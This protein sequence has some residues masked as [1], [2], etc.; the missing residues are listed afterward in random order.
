MKHSTSSRKLWTLAGLLALGLAVLFL[1]LRRRGGQATSQASTGQDIIPFRYIR[2]DLSGLSEAEA[3][4]KMPAF[5]RAQR[6]QEEEK[7]F[8]RRAFRLN[9]LSTFNIDIFAIALVMLL[10]GSPI[11][12]LGSM[13]V[14]LLNVT[15]N[16]VQITMTKKRL[17][18]ILATLSPQ[19]TVLRDSKLRSIDPVQIVEGDLLVI[20]SG[21]HILVDGELLSQESLTVEAFKPDQTT[22]QRVIDRGGSMFKGEDCVAGHGLYRAI[23]PGFPHYRVSPGSQVQLLQGERTPLENMMETILRGLLALVVVFSIV[24]VTGYVFPETEL[25]TAVYREAFSIVFAIAPTSLFFVLIMQYAMGAMRMSDLGAL[26]YKSQSIEALSNVSVICLSESSLMSGFEAKVEPISPPPGYASLSENTIR[27]FIGDAF[28]SL[29]AFS[30]LDWRSLDLFPGKHRQ[31]LESAVYLRESGWLGISFDDPDLR[32]TL[33]MGLPEAIKSSLVRGESKAL[34]DV[35]HTITRTQR[36]IRRLTNRIFKRDQK[37]GESE[38]ESEAGTQPPLEEEETPEEFP[39]PIQLIPDDF[40]GRPAWQQKLIGGLKRL[41]TPLEER[42]APPTSE[43][44]AD[45]KVRL[46][47]AYWPEPLTLHDQRGRASLPQLLIPLAYLDI[48]GTVRPE[49]RQVLEKFIKA[50]LQIKVLA[51]RPVEYILWLVKSM[52]W[53]TERL[54]AVSGAEL[55][56][57]G[58]SEYDQS[59]RQASLFSDLSP[60]QKTAIIGSLQRQGEYV[61][62]LGDQVSDIPAMRQANLRLALRSS[63]QATLALTDVVLIKDSLDALPAILVAG[64]RMVNSVLD[65]FKL[66]LSQVISQLIL[67]LAV[68]FVGMRHFPYNSTQGGIISAFTIAIPNIILSAWSA[69]GKLSGA[70]MRRRLIRFVVPASITLAILTFTVFQIFWRLDMPA[71]FPAQLLKNLRITNTRLFY[72]QLAATFALL[73]AGWLRLLFLQPPTRF[74]VGGAPLRG[75]RQVYRVV[76]GTAGLLA[77]LILFPFLPMQEWLRIT[78]LPQL[79]DYLL[80][81]SMVIAWAF[82]LRLVWRIG[83]TPSSAKQPGVH[84]QVRKLEVE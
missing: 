12:A 41:Q 42:Q 55:E 15:I 39:K 29:P 27:Y 64:Q 20:G 4:S 83:W 28:H 63:A 45:G 38:D 60:A 34:Q 8:L 17:D 35:S 81:G 56:D 53:E 37:P 36:G 67:I 48:G 82:V 51:S 33:V 73:F 65:T 32:G 59:V 71:I 43:V 78:W 46:L 70:E 69:S 16:T 19:A 14:L 68:L 44:E 10:L 74:W 57:L 7:L 76:L 75:D 49:S 66:Y 47:C 5:N 6:V 52:G 84:R 31:P 23:E 1:I 61:A 11:S 24:L 40:Y 13:L 18:Q 25:I 9:L 22:S 79:S 50:S 26:V 62:V 58:E 77:A 72:A 54:T 80:I 30:G 21:D 3:A 2:S